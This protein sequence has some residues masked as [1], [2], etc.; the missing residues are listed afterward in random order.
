MKTL[1]LSSPLQK[2]LAV[3]ALIFGAIT[4]FKSGSVL[5]GPQSA[6]EAVGLYV[7][8]VVKFNFV[9]GFF[10]GLAGVGMWLGRAWACKLSAVITLATLVIAAAFAWHVFRGGEYEMQTV[11]ALAVRAGFWL[12]VTLTLHKT[13]R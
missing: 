8:F 11:G 6:R 3:L 1:P 4:L 10:Y 9:A 2:T 13:R 7:P 5:F 12:A